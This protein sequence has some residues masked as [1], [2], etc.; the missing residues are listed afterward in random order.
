MKVKLYRGQRRRVRDTI[1]QLFLPCMVVLVAVQADAQTIIPKPLSVSPS[2]PE[3]FF[4]LGKDLS[5]LSAPQFLSEARLLAQKMKKVYGV[6]ARVETDA[7]RATPRIVLQQ[8]KKDQV[9]AEGYLLQVDAGRI[10]VEAS[11]SA[12]AYYGCISL[13][14]LIHKGQDGHLVVSGVQ[15]KDEPRFAWRGLMLD[16]SRTFLS[17]DYLKKTIDRMSFYKLNRLHLH[18]TDDQGWRLAIR[19][20][21]LLTSKGAFFDPRYNEPREF[22]GFYTQ[23][24]MRALIA[25][26]AQRHVTIIPEIECPGHNHAALYAY[27]EFSCSGSVSSIFPFFS[28]PGITKSVFCP[29]KPGTYRFFKSV[30]REVADIFPASYIHL[31]GDEVPEGAWDDCSDCKQMMDSL[32]IRDQQHLQGYMMNRIGREVVSSSKRPVGWDE[33]FSEGVTKDWVIMVW[34]GTGRGLAQVKAGYDVILCP[35]SNL[36]FDYSYAT[37]PTEKVYA[38]DPVPDGLT[39]EEQ[40]HYMGIQACF[41]SHIDRTESRIDYQLFPRVLALAERAWSAGSVTDYADFYQRALKQR[42]WLDYFDIKYKRFQP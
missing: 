17:V 18:L 13:L 4:K 22:Q 36:Y 40:R 25:Y 21:P 42:F 29:S 6:N 33:V 11:T 26:A 32:N 20:Y 9:S 34:R 3:A 8:V 37:T 31:G 28:G 41:W 27:P 2:G 14:Q 12:G 23:D 15:V 30:V 5:I 16:C 38:F 35:T 7:G 1:R 24:E 19:Q 39:A 10:T